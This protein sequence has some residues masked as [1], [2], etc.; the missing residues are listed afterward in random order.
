MLSR[1][2][3][4]KGGKEMMS[5]LLPPSAVSFE[6]PFPPFRGGKRVGASG[7][8]FTREENGQTMTV[9]SSPLFIVDRS[10]NFQGSSSRHEQAA[11]GP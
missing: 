10:W 9:Y 5:F 3:G 11:S 8:F 4:G 2:D 6:R 7:I 1:L